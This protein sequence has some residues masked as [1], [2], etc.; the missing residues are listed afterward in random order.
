MAKFLISIGGIRSV[1][2][3]YTFSMV[4]RNFPRAHIKDYSEGP[5]RDIR[6][7]DKSQRDRAQGPAAGDAE[8]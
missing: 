1:P 8:A 3:F 2:E 6:R 4:G 7:V 5:L